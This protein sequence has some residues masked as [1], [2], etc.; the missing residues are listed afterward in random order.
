MAAETKDRFSIFEE[1]EQQK[2]AQITILHDECNDDDHSRSAQHYFH[3][4][5][6]RIDVLYNYLF[7]FYLLLFYIYVVI[8]IKN[9]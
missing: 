3:F 9:C 5:E 1:T 2:E 4:M 6:R 7:L 8:Y